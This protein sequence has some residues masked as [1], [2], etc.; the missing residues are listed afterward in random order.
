MRR[1]GGIAA[2]LLSA[3]LLTA[4]AAADP[5]RIARPVDLAALPLLVMEREHLIE[6]TAEAMGLGE[7][8]VTWSAPDKAEPLAMLASGQSD[9]AMADL[10]PF[11]AAAAQSEMQALGAIAQRP[12]VLVA[13]NNA[14]QT[15][16]D[17]GNADRIAVPDLKASGPALMLEMAAAAE[18]GAEHYDKL[19][20]F[21]VARPDAAA[22][23]ALISGKGDIDAHFSR[24]PYVDDEL[25]N[26][27]IRRIMN[28]FD[29]A[30]PHSSA[31]LAATTR[32]AAA[33]AEL[34]K[35]ILAALQGADDFIQKTPGAAAEIF[36]AMSKGQGV[37][38]EDLSDMIGDPDLAYRA[39]PAGVQ[40]LA[41]FMQRIGRLKH[42]PQRWQDLFVPAARDLPG[43]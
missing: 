3:A 18:W 16:R 32:F 20:R 8:A 7:V 22:A 31:V 21:I 6:R 14:I 37:P 33:H 1:R 36:A 23:A 2:A 9:L 27:A 29:I 35:A 25:A 13:R 10:A 15:I 41:G 17:F 4:P 28:S 42:P 43:N 24:T 5:L 39:A 12:Y 38:L 26:P 30:G 11:L 40:R 34:C 19:D